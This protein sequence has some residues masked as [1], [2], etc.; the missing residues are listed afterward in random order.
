MCRSTLWPFKL[1]ANGTCVHPFRTLTLRH[2]QP[3]AVSLAAIAASRHFNN[4]CILYSNTLA[5]ET[6][7]LSKAASSKG[8][9]NR[10]SVRSQNIFEFSLLI[11]HFTVLFGY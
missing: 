8:S 2:A 1:Y 3:H 7:E 11:R 5:H 4:H 9:T 6:D 10:T